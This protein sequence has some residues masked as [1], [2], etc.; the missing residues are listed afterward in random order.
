MVEENDCLLKSVS[1][2]TQPTGLYYASTYIHVRIHDQ[3]PW[4]YNQLVFTTQVQCMYIY[5]ISLHDYTTNW[6]LLSK[7]V[8]T[9]TRSVSM[10]TQPTG[11]YCVSTYIYTTIY[12]CVC[13]KFH[14]TI[15]F[16]RRPIKTATYMY[17]YTKPKKTYCQQQ[18]IPVHHFLSPNFYV[19]H[20]QFFF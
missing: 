3:S 1:M 4:L 9:Y 2:T 6:S 13:N 17:M 7:Y 14:S 18:L 5:T 19:P 15:M 20:P 16:Y 8:R 12:F 10:T 11:L